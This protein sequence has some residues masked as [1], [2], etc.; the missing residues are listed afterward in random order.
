MS[1]VVQILLALLGTALLGSVIGWFAR[2]IIA[3]RDEDFL[4]QKYTK[5]IGNAKLSLQKSDEMLKQEQQKAS[6]LDHEITR[7]NREAIKLELA[8]L[9]TSRLDETL[10]ASNMELA[11]L[12]NRNQILTDQLSERGDEL[13]RATE[14]LNTQLFIARN[15][16][17]NNSDLLPDLDTNVPAT[18]NPTFTGAALNPQSTQPLDATQRRQTGVSAVNDLDDGIDPDIADMTA[19]IM[20]F[21]DDDDDLRSIAADQNDIALTHDGETAD[22]LQGSSET[23]GFFSNF[24]K[25]KHL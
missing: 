19:D 14:E 24:N 12:R 5:D 22:D 1:S 21:M 7:L 25:K 15:S 17:G 20:A 13:R 10:V 4:Y 8:A 2:R 6:D 11:E 23:G 16:S 9:E 3:I 18:A